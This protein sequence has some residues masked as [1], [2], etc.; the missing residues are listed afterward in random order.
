[1]KEKVIKLMTV[2][3]MVALFIFMIL[4]LIHD[5]ISFSYSAAAV[6]FLAAMTLD[7]VNTFRKAK[8]E[9]D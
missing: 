6:G 5:V 2:W 7:F 9:K 1:M 3:T 8:H 4:L